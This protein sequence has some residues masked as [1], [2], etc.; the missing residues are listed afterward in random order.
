MARETNEDW[1][2]ARNR[3]KDHYYQTDKLFHSA[4][5]DDPSSKFLIQHRGLS[6]ID[7]TVLV[8]IGVKFLLLLIDMLL[9]EFTFE[10]QTLTLFFLERKFSGLKQ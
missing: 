9:Y 7:A 2:K 6:Y 3:P 4:D 5:T 8:Y 1:P 10:R